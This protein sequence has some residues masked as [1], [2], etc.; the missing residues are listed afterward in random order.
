MEKKYAVYSATRNLYE[1]MIPSI[2]SLLANSDVDKIFLLI[3]DDTLPFSFPSCIEPINVSGQRYFP[4]DSPNANCQ[5]TYMV[6]LRAAYCYILSDV[7]KV[8]S[9]DVDTIVERDISSIWN[10]DISD[11]YIAGVREPKKSKDFLYINMGVT[12]HNLDKLRD[13]R[14]DQL[15][16]ILNTQ[17]Y[18][19]PEQDVFNFYCAG[20][21]FELPPEFN[22]SICTQP[23]TQSWIKHYAALPMDKWTKASEYKA[24]KLMDWREVLRGRK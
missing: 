24:Y 8:L 18:M 10:Y 13:G 15:I 2:K 23:S 21:I 5:W 22:C 11:Y 16:N 7:D 3:E 19:F 17:K 1:I 4:S 14:A 6:L 12:M 20:H 9:L